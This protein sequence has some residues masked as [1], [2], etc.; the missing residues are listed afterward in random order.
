[1]AVEI[2]PEAKEKAKEI[3]PLPKSVVEALERL[4]KRTKEQRKET[5][6]T[7][8]ESLI[9]KIAQETDL[10]KDHQK[11]L[12]T[13]VPVMV[14]RSIKPWEEEFLN[15]LVKAWEKTFDRSTTYTPQMAVERIDGYS[16]T[17]YSR[18]DLPARSYPDQLPQW[19]TLLGKVLSEDQLKKWNNLEKK[20]ENQANKVIKQIIDTNAENY[21]LRYGAKL[22]PMIKDIDTVLELKKNRKKQFEDAA[23]KATD[24]FVAQWR[25]Q[26]EDSLKDKTLK[27]RKS[28]AERGYLPVSVPPEILPENQKTWTT[29][30]ETILSDDE[31]VSWEAIKTGR[32][33]QR[34]RA[35]SLMMVT[36]LDRLF[37]LTNDQREKLEVIVKDSD[38][39]TLETQLKAEYWGS[40]SVKRLAQNARKMEYD[41]KIKPLLDEKQQKRWDSY[42]IKSS[43]STAARPTPDPDEP[44][45]EQTKAKAISQHLEWQEKLQRIKFREPLLLQ[46]EDVVRCTNIPPVVEERLILATKG[47][48]EQAIVKWAA[49]AGNRVYN[50][51]KDVSPEEI[52]KRLTGIG[53]YYTS[54][55]AENTDFW[56]GVVGSVLSEDQMAAWE[57]QKTARL[58][59][60][61]KA[62]T[63]IIINQL[64]NAIHLSQSQAQTLRPELDT[65]LMT[66]LP[67]IDRY[68][69]SRNFDTPW[70]LSSSYS[71]IPFRGIPEE[72]VK[73][74]LSKEQK[75]LWDEK[76]ESRTSGYWSTVQR[77]HKERTG[78]DEEEDEEDEDENKEAIKPA[79]IG[80]KIRVIRN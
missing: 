49:D 80:G 39:E 42:V 76:F 32:Q 34:K 12:K 3:A 51:V 38:L 72:F 48:T 1:M 79:Q 75:K 23:K 25:Q 73:E 78:K 33:K 69:A 59:F 66:Y 36:A 26:A 52:D 62:S 50:Q 77:Y 28:I 6:A 31:K 56:K 22:D 71:M 70:F 37:A 67:D 47:A 10:S 16:T 15:Y 4:V 2:K 24:E 43:T 44:K 46:V 11:Q 19:K 64:T 30:F 55:R 63:E 61:R 29:A 35:A 5:A 27:S 60:I 54:S 14:A 58:D 13:E 74:T 8:L 40:Q 41:E 53:T 9:T 57:T 68:F 17:S 65:A 18:V 21:R 7:E 45:N 20:E